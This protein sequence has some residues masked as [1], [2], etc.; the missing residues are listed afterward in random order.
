MARQAY[1]QSKSPTVRKLRKT[2]QALA[3]TSPQTSFAEAEQYICSVCNLPVKPCE[4]D[5]RAKCFH[6]LREATELQVLYSDERD[7]RRFC[8]SCEK[9]IT[10]KWLRKNPTAELCNSCTT[11]SAK[12]RKGSHLKGMSS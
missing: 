6:M 4:A 7:S 3:D 8:L 2:L 1:R 12:L 5:A 9:V 10:K 11:K